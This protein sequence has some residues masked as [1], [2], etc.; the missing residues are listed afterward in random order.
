MKDKYS[1]ITSQDY[2]LF[3]NLHQ[4]KIHDWYNNQFHLSG[5][6]GLI[7]D[8]NGLVFWEGQYYI[9]MQNC[10]FSTNHKNKSW[11]LYTTRDFIN[12][13][14]EGITIT[15]SCPYDKDGAFSGNAFIEN[16]QL[17]FYY[18]GN[19]KFDETKRTAFTLK[20]MIDLKTKTVTKKCLFEANRHLYSGHYRDPFVFQNENITFMLNGAQTLDGKGVLNLLQSNGPSNNDWQS[21]NNFSWEPP[22]KDPFY[23]LECPSLLQF[24]EDKFIVFSGE[25]KIS[26]AD[27]SH[28]VWYQKNNFGRDMNLTSNN[29]LC[30]L[31]YGLDFYAP[32]NIK[33]LPNR[34]IIIGW[35]GNSQATT[36]VNAKSGWFS[37]LTIPRLVTNVNGK[38][39]Q[40][41][42]PELKQLRAEL[43]NKEKLVYDN[44]LLEFKASEIP[45]KFNFK[46]KNIH[47]EY[48][49]ITYEN[50]ELIIDRHHMTLR[51]DKNLPPL[52]KIHIP[53]VNNFHIL[54][55][56][57]CCEVFLNDGDYPISIHFFVNNHQEIETNLCP[58][59]AYTLQPLNFIAEENIIFENILI[60]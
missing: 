57:S 51:D 41:P 28:M 16:N 25:Q 59:E 22:N 30:L 8:P 27:N 49:L 46:I 26:F 10:P 9:F 60:D 43:I 38:L 32:Q 15:P 48:L 55:D 47:D 23:M 21:L 54:I 42:I 19:Y 6:S 58:S 34:H 33:N 45:K 7:N 35:L 39:R 44:G 2:S 24:K 13:R 50:Q 1:W 40:E 5:Y 11:A 53:Q 4:K 18:T 3:S 31:D 37:Q 14:Y 52:Q 56:R 20:A 36:E 17:V 12:Y 29:P